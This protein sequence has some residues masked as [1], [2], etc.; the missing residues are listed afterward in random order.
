MA[1]DMEDTVGQ[2]T[3]WTV[4]TALCLLALGSFG[5]SQFLDSEQTAEKREWR[6]G[7]KYDV[8]DSIDQVKASVKELKEEQRE[9]AKEIRADTGKIQD[10]LNRLL[11]T[12]SRRE[13]TH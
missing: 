11:L 3:F 5:H 10:G 2:K 4:C 13:R 7:F 12:D 9:Q 1:N 8:K 6:K